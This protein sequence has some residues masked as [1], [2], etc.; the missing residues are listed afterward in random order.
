[1]RDGTILHI[2]NS[3]YGRSDQYGARSRWIVGANERNQEMAVFSRAGKGN[4]Q[5]THVPVYALSLPVSA[6]A[7]RL[8][9]KLTVR[10]SAKRRAIGAGFDT[11]LVNALI[12]VSPEN[13]VLAHVWDWT[14][15]AMSWLR[16]RFPAIRI[17]R[18]VVVNRYYD[19]YSGRP[20]TDQLPSTDL[21]LAPSR[22]TADQLL[23]WGI[24]SEKIVEIPFGVDIKTYKPAASVPT[25]PLRFA[26]SGAVSRRK[27]VDSLLRVWRRLDLADA[28]LHLYGKVRDVAHE[29]R[30]ARRVVAHGHVELPSQLPNNHVY[31]FPSTLEG[32]AKS[33]YEALA[34]GLPVIT[35]P[36]SGSI[37]RDGIEGLI[38]PAGDD[39]ALL[40]A[41]R[42]LAL[43]EDLRVQFGAAARERA[44][45]H[46]WGQYAR[47]VWE[48]YEA[49]IAM[50]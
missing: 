38:V 16:N 26:F 1:M 3:I 17:I 49:L 5:Q 28:E 11:A 7:R 47:R 46:T 50:S 21:F 31:V 18:D 36:E 42:R 20:I 27:G 22:Y 48:A 4:S 35:T 12:D 43:D 25:S 45:A 24:P 10:H 40:E 13:V 29:L 32:S 14:P 9:A 8:T 19:F 2:M 15:R 33:V 37:V 39:D 41:M 34:C 30:A 6:Q 44:V 23:S